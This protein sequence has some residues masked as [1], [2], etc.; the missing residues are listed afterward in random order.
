MTLNLTELNYWAAYEEDGY[1][2]DQKV[3][4][5]LFLRHSAAF[6]KTTQCFQDIAGSYRYFM[7]IVNNRRVL[8]NSPKKKLNS[9][10]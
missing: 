8:A 3:E 7:V 2:K 6:M 1:G 9:S 5:S 10:L 4:L